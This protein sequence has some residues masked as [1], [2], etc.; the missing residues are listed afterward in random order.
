MTFFQSI[1][2]QSN[3]TL[4]WVLDIDIF[5]CFSCFGSIDNSTNYKPENENSI[6][7]TTFP[8]DRMFPFSLNEFN[9]KLMWMKA[10]TA[11]FTEIENWNNFV[12]YAHFAQHLWN[13][14]E[15]F[16]LFVYR[17]K[18]HRERRSKI[19]KSKLSPCRLSK[20]NFLSVKWHE[21]QFQPFL[22]WDS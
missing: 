1:F 15:L 9:I 12:L 18:Q 2:Q 22:S 13:E 19:K 10:T 16:N 6:S 17:Q 5:S 14:M 7:L 3:D 4:H 8:I 20:H 21:G 11:I